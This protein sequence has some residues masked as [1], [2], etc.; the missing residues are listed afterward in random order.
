MDERLSWDKH[1]DFI[2]SKVG[3]GNGAMRR[4]KPF[5]TTADFKNTI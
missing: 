2:C 3:A 1:I 4:V 5:C